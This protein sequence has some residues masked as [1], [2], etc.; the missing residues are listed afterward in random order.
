MT[1]KIGSMK[2]QRTYHQ[3]ARQQSAYIEKDYEKS[4]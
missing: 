3:R 1:E 4:I 2:E